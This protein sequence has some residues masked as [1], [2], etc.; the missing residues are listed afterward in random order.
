MA[1]NVKANQNQSLH[2]DA[3]MFRK[4]SAKSKH[5]ILEL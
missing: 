3:H 2:A 4:T 5:V 1:V